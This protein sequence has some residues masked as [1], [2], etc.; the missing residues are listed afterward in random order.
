LRAHIAVEPET[1]I[2]TVSTLTPANASDALI[3]PFVG[4]APSQTEPWQQISHILERL[5][6]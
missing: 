4:Q 1:G 6:R 3:L 5:S 2:I